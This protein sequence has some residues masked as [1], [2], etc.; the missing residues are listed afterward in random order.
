M[1][2][3]KVWFLS[4]GVWSAVEVTELSV[5]PKKAVQSIKEDKSFKLS[6]QSMSFLKLRTSLLSKKLASDGFE[7]PSEA[8]V[9]FGNKLGV[10]RLRNGWFKL[11]PVTAH[12][13]SNRASG[14]SIKIRETDDLASSDEVVVFGV[15]YLRAAEMD[16][17]SGVAAELDE[18]QEDLHS[19]KGSSHE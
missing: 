8:L 4:L 13:E 11:V 3:L 1:I 18:G 19:S 10:Y 7:V 2:F 5:G 14:G 12:I 17:F 6:S 16:A 9:R 15:S